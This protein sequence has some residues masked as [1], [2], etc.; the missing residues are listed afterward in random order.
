MPGR[1]MPMERFGTA[2]WGRTGLRPGI[3]QAAWNKIALLLSLI[4]D[5]QMTGQT[6]RMLIGQAVHAGP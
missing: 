4:A 1:S 5:R 2:T 6:E 3:F